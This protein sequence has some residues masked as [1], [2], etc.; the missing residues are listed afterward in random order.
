MPPQVRLP[1]YGSQRHPPPWRG[2]FKAERQSREPHRSSAEYSISATSLQ[3]QI[4]RLSRVFGITRRPNQLTQFRLA[5]SMP[6]R[7]GR[8]MLRAGS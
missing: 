6:V 5:K 4:D 8:G 3:R 1:G 2:E 7:S